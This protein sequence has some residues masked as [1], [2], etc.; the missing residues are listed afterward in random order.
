MGWT[1]VVVYVVT[2]SLLPTYCSNGKGE[3]THPIICSSS[4]SWYS[5]CHYLLFCGHSFYKIMP[6]KTR[7]IFVDL[8]EL[9]TYFCVTLCEAVNCLQ[10]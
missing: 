4:Y 7:Y 10:Q 3:F 5:L 8:Q 9:R 2:L 1:V 6:K